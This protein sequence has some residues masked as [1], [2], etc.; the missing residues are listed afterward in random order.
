[1]ML[2]KLGCEFDLVGNGRDAYEMSLKHRY[3]AI[4]M[5][6]QMPIMDGITASG[7]IREAERKGLIGHKNQ[8]IALTAGSTPENMERCTKAGMDGNLIIENC[9]KTK[10]FL[11][12]PIEFSTVKSVVESVCK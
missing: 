3:D 12:K 6:V 1:M 11:T 5:D 10:G 8:I 4:F 2:R 9:L 7:M